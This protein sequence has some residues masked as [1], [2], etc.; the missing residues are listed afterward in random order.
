M[1]G[2]DDVVRPVVYVKIWL[3]SFS[4]TAHLIK[5]KALTLPNLNFFFVPKLNH[6]SSN[7]M[8][9]LLKTAA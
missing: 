2:L 1:I 8:C 9:L 3:G 6:I 5:E 4:H 7:G